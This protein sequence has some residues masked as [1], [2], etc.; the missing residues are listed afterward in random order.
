MSKPTPEQLLLEVQDVI[1]SMPGPRDF[2]VNGDT[3]VVWLGRASAVMSNWDMPRSTVHFE[4]EV[5]RYSALYANRD[6]VNFEPLRHSLLML[7]HQA[8]NDLRLKTSGPLSVGIGTGRVF[9]YF[10]EIRKLIEGARADLL[11]VDPYIDA[12]FVSR[13]L[14]LVPDGTAVR[15]LARERLTTLKPA[16]AAFIAQS[17]KSVEVRTCGGFHDRYLFIDG[18]AC[19]QSGASFKDGAKKAPTVLTQIT[20]AVS[21]VTTTYEQL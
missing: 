9:E 5:R 18:Q 1:R 15:I 4:P 13:Y 11:F 7:L 21:A 19:Y 16:V 10:D 3:C 17:G 2:S 6:R 14:P 12:E 20:D 8:E